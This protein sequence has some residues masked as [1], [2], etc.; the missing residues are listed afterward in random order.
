[1]S[2]CPRCGADYGSARPELPFPQDALDVAERLL[3]TPNCTVPRDVMR[4]VVT[5]CRAR[6]DAVEH[7]TEGNA[8]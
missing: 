8:A 1:M 6:R 5:E 3:A 2:A 4:A 7:H